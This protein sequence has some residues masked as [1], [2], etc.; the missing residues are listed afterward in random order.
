MNFL[1][2]SQERRSTLRP[3]D[4]LVYGWEGGKHACVNLTR[5]SLCGAGG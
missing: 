5:V 1:T 2:N 3:A 4:V